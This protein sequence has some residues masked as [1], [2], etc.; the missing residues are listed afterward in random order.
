MMYNHSANKNAIQSV[1]INGE[2]DIVIAS[3][4]KADIRIEEQHL[5]MRIVFK[6]GTF[7]FKGDHSQYIDITEAPSAFFKSFVVYGVFAFTPASNPILSTPNA[8]CCA[9]YNSSIVAI[10]ICFVYKYKIMYQIVQ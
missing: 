9:L 3:H 6:Y 8:D 5:N 10:V 7:Y 2:K 1:V 4:Q